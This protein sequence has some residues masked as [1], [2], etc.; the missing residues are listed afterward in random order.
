MEEPRT[1]SSMSWL[2]KIFL[3]ICMLPLLVVGA[4][5]WRTWSEAAKRQERLAGRINTLVSRESDLER[6]RRQI[7][8]QLERT[9]PEQDQAVK[10]LEQAKRTGEIFQRQVTDRDE[11]IK[12][13]QQTIWELQ[14]RLLTYAKGRRAYNQQLRALW[15]LIEKKAPEFLVSY[16]KV[17]SNFGPDG[18]I[19]KEFEPTPYSG[20]THFEPMWGGYV[21]SFEGR[22]WMRKDCV[23]SPDH[24]R[25]IW[26]CID[27]CDV[28]ADLYFIDLGAHLEIRIAS[29]GA[30]THYSFLTWLDNETFMYVTGEGFPDWSP[31][32]IIYRAAP[33]VIFSRIGEHSIPPIK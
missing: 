5:T 33:D 17:Y 9:A 3:F 29:G 27:D 31:Q 1:D 19:S 20:G 16:G 7:S 22:D 23:W 11:K 28:D 32:L 8:D 24:Q 6:A 14:R 13:R 25:C 10:D 18:F 4:W 12:E 15:P 30:A 2:G 26:T 21:E